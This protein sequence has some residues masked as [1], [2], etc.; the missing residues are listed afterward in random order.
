[1][2]GWEAL[3][4]WVRGSMLKIRWL[5]P[6]GRVS[7]RMRALRMRETDASCQGGTRRRCQRDGESQARDHFHSKQ[8]SLSSRVRVA[9]RRSGQRR[10]QFEY[11]WRRPASEPRSHVHR[12]RVLSGWQPVPDTT[13][14]IL[15][16][17]SWCIIAICRCAEPAHGAEFLVE[18]LQLA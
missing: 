18:S 9:W 6:G 11:A 4:A 7:R 1:M 3:Q 15:A 14:V 2:G 13:Q 16:A 8:R 17:K 12:T 5:G 10:V